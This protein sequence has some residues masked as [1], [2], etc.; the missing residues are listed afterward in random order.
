[1]RRRI[2]TKTETYRDHLLEYDEST[3]LWSCPDLNVE[4]TNSYKVI[5]QR[6]DALLKK[7]SLRVKAYTISGSY[8]ES[9][10]VRP[11]TITSFVGYNRCWT[12][13][14]H[15]ERGKYSLSSLY[16]DTKDNVVK[17]GI[18]QQKLA[19]VAKLEKEIDELTDQ[20]TVVTNP[21]S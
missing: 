4:P 6:V 1:M 17:L 19:I 12:T 14:Q 16:A 3:D 8:F 7:P 10:R 9:K 11:V 2:I 13:D 15:K 20:L 5:K 21:N 18:I